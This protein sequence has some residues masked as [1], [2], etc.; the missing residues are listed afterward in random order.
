MRACLSWAALVY[1]EGVHTKVQE[2]T[3]RNTA[4]T[5]SRPCARV[6]LVSLCSSPHRA[7][8]TRH[9]VVVN[10]AQYHKARPGE[11][12]YKHNDCI[13]DLFP[14]VLAK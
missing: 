11:V 14:A 10:D 12:S 2:N 4:T 3:H 13:S 1:L 6:L 9:I 7:S 5:I 8:R